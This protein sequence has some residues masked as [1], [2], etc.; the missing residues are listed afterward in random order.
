MKYG[1]IRIDD[2]NLIFTKRMMTNSLPCEDI[3]WAYRRKED[4]GNKDGAAAPGNDGNSIIIRT[5]KGK[6]YKFDMTEEETKACLLHLR[7]LNPWMS[8]GFP[9]GTRIPLQNLPNTR[10][11]GALKTVDGRFILPHKL[12]R[13]GELYHMSKA[14]VRTLR[15]EYH[16]T[17][18]VD[19][20]TD[21]ERTHKP[22]T[23]MEGVCYIDN[24]ILEEETVGITREKGIMELLMA[25]DGEPKSYMEQT[26]RS[27]ALDSFSTN[28]YAKFFQYLLE[29]E[30]GAILW[31]CTAGK[32]RVGVGTAL[33]LSALGVPREAIYED[34][35]RTNQYLEQETEYMLQLLDS[36]LKGHPEAAENI[37]VMM[38][39]E[40]RYLEGVF[41]AIEAEYG[42]MDRYLKK[43]MCLTP[44]ALER[45]QNKYLV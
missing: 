27:L 17:T 2:G 22:D 14:D 38:S 4:A 5:R 21:A 37:K 18:V 40:Q 42:S 26:Y 34:Y 13:S 9:K 44:K 3:L 10:D 28:Q 6:R 15:E 20:R 30:N 36:R 29:Q 12:I 35:L 32:D 1:K 19:F 7:E 16:V 31:H 11:L 43:K 39:V 41:Q 8:L 33:L 45:L 24:P 25:F 23:E